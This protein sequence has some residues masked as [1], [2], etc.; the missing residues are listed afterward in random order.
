MMLSQI[1]QNTLLDNDDCYSLRILSICPF[2]LYT[3]QHIC[4]LFLMCHLLPVPEIS[5]FISLWKCNHKLVSGVLMDL[6]L[7]S[8]IVKWELQQIFL[9]TADDM[10]PLHAP[11]DQLSQTIFCNTRNSI[12]FSK[13]C[14]AAWRPSKSNLHKLTLIF[15]LIK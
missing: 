2:F 14:A 13:M 3:C 9:V 8:K 12:Y 7:F 6:F 4:C 1:C 11:C 10:A 5:V 15:V